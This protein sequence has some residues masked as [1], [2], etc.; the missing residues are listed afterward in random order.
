M[1]TN[2]Q[3]PQWYRR[4][5]KAIQNTVVARPF[6]SFLVTLGLLL[7]FIV[8]GN[9]MSKPQVET[10][11]EEP[12]IKE[13]STYSIGTSPKMQLQAQVKKTGTVTI[14]A[15]SNGIV[16]QIYKNEGDKVNK[17]ATLLWIST[18]YSGGTV[19]SAQREQ[20]QVNY[21]FN[22]NNIQAQ[23]DTIALQR[24]L[25][26]KNRDNTEELR[27]IGVQSKSESIGVIE[28]N[29]KSIKSIADTV[30]LLEQNTARTPEEESTLIGLRSQ[31]A[32][33]QSAV[34]QIRQANRQVEYQTDTK[35]IPN[36]LADL[37]RDLTFKQL[38]VQ[39]KALTLQLEVS[40]LN[41]QLAQIGEGLNYPASPYQGVV[42]QLNVK[43]GQMVN[44]GQVLAV[45]TAN[46]SSA[47][48][49][50]LV[51]EQV[52]KKINKTQASI[53]YINGTAVEIMP[54]YVST[55]PTT[56]QMY[57]IKY[58][59][60]AENTAQVSDASFIK[61]EIPI[62]VPDTSA[63]IPFIPVDAVFQTQDGAYVYTAEKKD[64]G[65][66]ARSK[67]ITLGE[68]SGGFIEVKSGLVANDLVITDRNVLEGDLVKIKQ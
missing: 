57:S 34:N 42:E 49:E 2:N 26:V 43:S 24:D 54:T 18:N 60:P 35:N 10:K 17:G 8:A 40:R 14:Y 28:T 46:E 5:A 31:Q 64:Q 30:A 66:D 47:S 16:Q 39:E 51:S 4:P 48:V 41:Y 33:L 3:S 27:K 63:A 13:V 23:K 45:I 12:V 53:I 58:Q 55:Q 19:S 1:E 32:Q 7:G 25:A 38:D 52:A 6:V 44:P 22:K 62:G 36:Q 61:I 29:D 65:Y 20:A 67:K 68:L 11:K 50:T 15:Q 21:T 9:S 56:G 59:V 37:Q